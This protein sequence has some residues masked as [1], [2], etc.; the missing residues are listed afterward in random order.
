MRY[1]LI[2]LLLAGCSPPTD[3]Q[4]GHSPA[5]LPQ[6]PHG[7]SHDHIAGHEAPDRAMVAAMTSNRAERFKAA[8]LQYIGAALAYES[9]PALDAPWLEARAYD[10][11][12]DFR[13]KAKSPDAEYLAA[14]YY[15]NLS[16]KELLDYVREQKASK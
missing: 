4:I 11:L 13:T 14:D 15:F 9:L 16:I 2:L 12:V 8:E 7:H 1:V 10:A 3:K 6:R 5:P